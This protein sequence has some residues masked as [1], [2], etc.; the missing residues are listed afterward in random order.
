M[1]AALVIYISLVGAAAP[2]P[3]KVVIYPTYLK[4]QQEAPAEVARVRRQYVVA[5]YA[6]LK[7][8]VTPKKP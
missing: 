8:P 4:C 5:Q 2:W 6:C 1:G 3:H 7:L